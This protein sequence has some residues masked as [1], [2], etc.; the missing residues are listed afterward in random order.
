M[1]P[2]LHLSLAFYGRAPAAPDGPVIIC[3]NER[4]LG[5][6]ALVDALR[7]VFTIPAALPAP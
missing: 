6:A 2:V 7:P 3:R 4:G 5:M 1:S